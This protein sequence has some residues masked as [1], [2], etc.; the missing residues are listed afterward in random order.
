MQTLC[1][2][3]THTNLLVTETSMTFEKTVVY[4]KFV[5]PPL[6]YTPMYIIV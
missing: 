2:T 1:V 3:T 5:V 6:N 4:K